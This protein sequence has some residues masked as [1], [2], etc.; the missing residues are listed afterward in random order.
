[1]KRLPQI[2]LIGSILPLSW[3]GMMIVHE[4]GHVIGAWVSGGTVAKVVLHPFAISRTDPTHNSHPLVFVWAGPLMGVLLSLETFASTVALK[5]PVTYILRFFVGFCAIANGSYI[6][7]GSFSGVGDAGNLSQHGTA[8][9]QLWTF[10]TVTIPLEFVLWH[11]LGPH[12]GLGD[13]KGTVHPVVAY[14]SLSLLLL[15]I[16]VE[17]ALG[18]K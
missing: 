15:V 8:A 14:V 1:M 4:F 9:G 12:F 13:A 18:G 10:G 16:A 17:L 2:I 11:R 3:L 5:I 6:A 7:V